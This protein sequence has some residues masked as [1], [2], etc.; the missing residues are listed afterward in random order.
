MREILIETYMDFI[1]NYLTV[2]KFAEHNGLLDAEAKVLL[3]LARWVAEHPHPE[4]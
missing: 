2:E 3:E 4:A 1:N